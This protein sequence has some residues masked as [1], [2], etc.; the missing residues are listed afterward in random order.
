MQMMHMFRGRMGYNLTPL[1]QT[2]LLS[3]LKIVSRMYW[4][5][6]VNLDKE[7]AST[8]LRYKCIL[9]QVRTNV[10]IAFCSYFTL[11]WGNGVKG[12]KVLLFWCLMQKGEKL[13]AKANGSANHLRIS[14]IV[15]LESLCL[16][17]ILL[18][19]KLFSYG[20]EIWLWEKGEFVTFDQIFS[21]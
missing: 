14:K 5:G 13:R 1:R 15:E 20:G 6:K 16:I 10:L 21:W 18:T 19:Q 11:W 9:S 8:A 3:T 7:R 12:P 4:K 17:K 2:Y